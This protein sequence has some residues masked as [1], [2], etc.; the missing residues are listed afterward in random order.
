MIIYHNE[1]RY[2]APLR[3]AA[4]AADKNLCPFCFAPGFHAPGCKVCGTF[5][6]HDGEPS[7]F[8][9]RVWRSKGRDY[10]PETEGQEI[11]TDDQDADVQDEQDTDEI[12]FAA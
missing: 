11:D 4:P 5:G 1:P 3:T 9:R 10:V 12:P 6:Y 7:N 8:R 2:R